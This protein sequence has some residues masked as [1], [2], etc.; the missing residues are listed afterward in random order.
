MFSSF[1][2]ATGESA[3]ASRLTKIHL[4]SIRQTLL[5]LVCR[6]LPCSSH[7]M[8][9]CHSSPQERLGAK[10]GGRNDNPRSLCW[11]PRHVLQDN[12]VLANCS[13]SK[14]DSPAYSVAGKRAGNPYS[15][16]RPC[17]LYPP[18]P[19]PLLPLSLSLSLSLSPCQAHSFVSPRPAT[20]QRKQP[21]RRFQ[22]YRQANNMET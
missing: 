16:C 2:V 17:H 7:F 22:A 3:S 12:I 6:L 10:Q 13:I 20:S 14:A 5:G 21:G 18:C 15:P 11:A 1:N 4:T 8:C 19:T 9:T